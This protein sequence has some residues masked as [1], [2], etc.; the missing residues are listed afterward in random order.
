[1]KTQTLDLEQKP[2]STIQLYQ[3]ISNLE[4]LKNIT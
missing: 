3:E 2:Y 1:M 4:G